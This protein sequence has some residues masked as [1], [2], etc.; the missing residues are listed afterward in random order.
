MQDDILGPYVRW[1][2]VSDRPN[3]PSLEE[4]MYVYKHMHAADGKTSFSIKLYSHLRLQ[5]VIPFP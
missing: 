2:E 3:L 5:S 1:G 4:D